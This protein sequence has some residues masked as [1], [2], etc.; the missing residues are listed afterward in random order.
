MFHLCPQDE[1]VLN[2]IK[3]VCDLAAALSPALVLD[4]V[5]SH[6]GL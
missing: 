4:T 6:C 5:L 2:D 1:L 3:T